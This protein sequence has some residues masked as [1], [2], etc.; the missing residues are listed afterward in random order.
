MVRVRGIASRLLPGPKDRDPGSDVAAYPRLALLVDGRDSTAGGNA[1]KIRLI[2]I[3]RMFMISAVLVF[4]DS[5]GT[6]LCQS[7]RRYSSSMLDQRRQLRQ[8]G[9]ANPV[10]GVRRV[11]RGWVSEAGN[12]RFHRVPGRFQ[13]DP[14]VILGWSCHHCHSLRVGD[15]STLM[16]LS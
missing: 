15:C 2:P 10:K 1:V 4:I 16:R 5:C 7:R 11:G 8:R 13:D 9:S 12:H 14:F 3:D 6:N